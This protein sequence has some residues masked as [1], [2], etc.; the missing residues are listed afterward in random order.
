MMQNKHKTMSSRTIDIS[1]TFPALQ[2]SVSHGHIEESAREGVKTI[3][4]VQ[5]QVQC[6]G[7]SERR[8]IVEREKEHLWLDDS[9]SYARSIVTWTAKALQGNI[10]VYMLK[11]ATIAA[12]SQ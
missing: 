11:R 7:R 1:F 6:H 10:S 3:A 8:F 2:S 12:V 5:M 9:Q 4:E